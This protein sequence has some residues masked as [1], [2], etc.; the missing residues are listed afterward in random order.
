LKIVKIK[1][2]KTL[3]VKGIQ[4][5][6]AAVVV[7]K[8][9]YLSGLTAEQMCAYDDYKLKDIGI[10]FTNIVERTSRSSADLTRYNLD[11]ALFFVNMFTLMMMAGVCVCCLATNCTV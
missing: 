9:L 7:G 11:T 4:C 6:L 2:G 3:R 5:L 1:D 8:C 10:G